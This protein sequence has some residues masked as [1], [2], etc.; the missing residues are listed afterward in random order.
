[1]GQLNNKSIPTVIVFCM[2]F[3]TICGS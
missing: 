1:M 3:A 2:L